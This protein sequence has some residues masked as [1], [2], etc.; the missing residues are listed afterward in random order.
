MLL[1]GLGDA[2]LMLLSGHGFA[3]VSAVILGTDVP[4]LV[5]LCGQIYA[6]IQAVGWA[7]SCQCCCCSVATDSTLLMLL[8]GHRVTMLLCLCELGMEL[9]LLLLWMLL[10][11]RVLMQLQLL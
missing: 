10:Q 5:L 8:F 1:F 7:Q 3:T 2:V 4:L 11:L 6:I 9:L